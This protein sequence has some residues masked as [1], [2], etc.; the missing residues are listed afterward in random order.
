MA[1]EPTQPPIQWVP[2]AFSL[3]IKRPGREADHSPP[4]SAEVKEW[5]EL[6]LHFHNTPSWRDAAQLQH[7]N[8]FSFTI[9]P[10]DVPWGLSGYG[11]GEENNC[12]CRE[13]NPETTYE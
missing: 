8:N 3:G 11:G 2:G 1:L 5:V 4:S 6:Y 9:L 13:S 12:P 7:R 10:I